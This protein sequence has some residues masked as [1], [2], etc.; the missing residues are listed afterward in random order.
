MKRFWLKNLKRN[1][2]IK[3][4]RARRDSQKRADAQF[5]L[6]PRPSGVST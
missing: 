5:P 3:E 1:N 6:N 4:W 2:L